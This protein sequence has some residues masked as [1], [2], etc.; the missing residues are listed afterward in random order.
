MGQLSGV[1][2]KFTS[3]A[4]AAQ[5]SQV[6]ILGTDLYTAHQAMLWWHIQNGG[7]LACMLAQG[8]L[9]SSTK[10]KIRNRC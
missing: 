5:G 8:K 1:V 2:V 4:S 7:G 3:S 10:G 6:Q 9:S